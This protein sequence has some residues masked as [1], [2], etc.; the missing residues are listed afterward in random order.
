M[1]LVHRA[2][3]LAVLSTAF[4]EVRQG[5]GRV[6]LVVGGLAGGKTAVLQRHCDDAA[7]ENALVLTAT[8]ARAERRL[9]LGLIDQLFNAAALP[10]ET[11]ARARRLLTVNPAVTDDVDEESSMLGQSD[12]RTVRALCDLLLELARSGPVVIGVDDVHFADDASLQVLL[13]LCRR[14]KRAPVLLILTEWA[15]PLPTRPR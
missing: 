15:R 1:S 2:D 3:E 11:V 13:Y 14:L 4:A 12:A 6:V 10:A 5:R 7:A 8:G 9:R